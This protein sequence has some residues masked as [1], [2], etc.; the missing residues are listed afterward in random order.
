[1][2]VAKSLSDT[3]KLLLLAIALSGCSS[4][5]SSK[6]LGGSPPLQAVTVLCDPNDDLSNRPPSCETS[7][8]S[9]APRAEKTS[10]STKPA[11]GR[12]CND[13]KSYCELGIITNK[14]NYSIIKNDGVNIEVVGDL[15]TQ[16]GK[17]GEL[18]SNQAGYTSS[19]SSSVGDNVP[20]IREEH[21]DMSFHQIVK[22]GQPIKITGL[23][24]SSVSLSF[25]RQ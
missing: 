4:E 25:I 5:T 24:G 19:V 16:V 6:Q 22:I 2:I 9:L 7:I 8:A 1:M 20:L 3:A 21:K 10:V 13:S 12:I 18:R 11:G 15:D 23:V 17:D 14:F